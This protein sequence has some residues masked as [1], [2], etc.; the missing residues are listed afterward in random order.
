[1]EILVRQGKV[2]SIGCSNHAAWQLCRALWTQ[3]V[4]K[5]TRFESAQECYNLTIRSIEK[6]TIPLALDQQVGVVVYSPLGAGFLTG[7]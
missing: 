5:W 4:N 3:D 1:M 2:V 6:D 7:K